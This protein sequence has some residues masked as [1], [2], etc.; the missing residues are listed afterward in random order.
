[1]AHLFATMVY[2]CVVGYDYVMEML[3]NSMCLIPQ[4]ALT[5]APVS[6]EFNFASRPWLQV[7]VMLLLLIEMRLRFFHANTCLINL[8]QT[9]TGI[10]IGCPSLKGYTFIPSCQSTC[11]A[12]DTWQITSDLIQQGGRKGCS[13]DIAHHTL[14]AYLA[15][16]RSQSVSCGV[17]FVDLQVAFYS[18]LRSSLFDEEMHDDLIC[19]AMQRLGILPSESA[20]LFSRIMQFKVGTPT[21]ILKDM[22]AGTHFTMRSC[23]TVTATTPHVAPDLVILLLM[24]FSIW[25]FAW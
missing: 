25:P 21:D 1:M 4:R 24:C 13:T 3:L 19:V 15:W 23:P 14:H 20:T 5:C 8:H 12:T 6:H 7:P 18:I 10:G 11:S 16:V 2:F 9:Q 22:F 17:L